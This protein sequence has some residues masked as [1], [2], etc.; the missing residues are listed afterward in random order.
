MGASKGS[1]MGIGLGIDVI[2]CKTGGGGRVAWGNV[3]D[4][5]VIPLGPHSSLSIAYKELHLTLQKYRKL[6][7]NA[8]WS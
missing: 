3:G 1:G 4:S 2:D 7:S 6:K 5:S 8:L